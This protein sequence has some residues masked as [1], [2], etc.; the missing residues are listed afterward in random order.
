MEC[1]ANKYDDAKAKEGVKKQTLEETYQKVG[2]ESR[3][4]HS[5]RLVDVQRPEHVATQIAFKYEPLQDH[6][7][8]MDIWKIQVGFY[9]VNFEWD[10]FEGR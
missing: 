4:W 1:N 2:R 6:C 3:I 8:Q 10:F 9:D 7:L 5:A